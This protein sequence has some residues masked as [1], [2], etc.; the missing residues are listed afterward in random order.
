[1]RMCLYFWDDPKDTA[2]ACT[3]WWLGPAVGSQE[4]FAVCLGRRKTPDLCEVWKKGA[5]LVDV[6]VVAAP[7]RR[8]T[9]RVLSRDA[10]LAGIYECRDERGLDKVYHRATIMTMAR[11]VVASASTPALPLPPATEMRVSGTPGTPGP[12]RASALPPVAVAAGVLPPVA[13][14]VAAGALLPGSS[15]RDTLIP[16]KPGDVVVLTGDPIHSSEPMPGDRLVA[17]LFYQLKETTGTTPLI[18]SATK[19]TL[20]DMHTCTPHSPSADDGAGPAAS[21]QSWSQEK[22]AEAALRIQSQ[23]RCD[24]SREAFGAETWSGITNYST[25]RHHDKQNKTNDALHP[26]MLQ[27]EEACRPAL[28]AALAAQHKTRHDIHLVEAFVNFYNNSSARSGIGKHVDGTDLSVII[29]LTNEGLFHCYIDRVGPGVDTH[30]TIEQHPQDSDAA[31]NALQ[32]TST[33]TGRRAHSQRRCRISQ[34]KFDASVQ[35]QHL[36]V[37][38]SVRQVHARQR[39]GGAGS[40]PPL[41]IEGC[42]QALVSSPTMCMCLYFWDDPKDTAGACTG[43]WLGP[44]VGS[45]EYFA[46][47]LGRRKTPDLCEVWKKGANLVDVCVVAAPGRRSTFRVLS[48]DANL[49]GVYTKCMNKGAGLGAAVYTRGGHTVVGT[50]P[51]HRATLCAG[52]TNRAAAPTKVQRCKRVVSVRAGRMT[53]ATKDLA[54]ARPRMV[55]YFWDDPK[56]TAGAC[57]GWWLGPAVGSQEYFAVCLGR[58]K[59]PDL[60]EVWKKGANLVD[61]CVVAAPGRRSTFR[62]LSRDA[63]LAGL[64]ECSDE[65]GLDKVY[66]HATGSDPHHTDGRSRKRKRE[67]APTPTTKHQRATQKQLVFYS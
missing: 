52:T 4:Y 31:C 49:A 64:Y 38:K 55:L 18:K 21:C 34:A 41:H 60:C 32:G 46:V 61:V 30:A 24:L 20:S 58:R 44:A 1:M 65:R 39:H 51:A 37:E 26:L 45:Q 62:V 22:I 10:N 56:D 8:S 6:C 36:A 66:Y 17:L 25:A 47:C 50:T 15:K 28:G 43:W 11:A 23:W 9:F 40:A 2:S 19:G 54:R 16:L 7:G 67:A 13:V 59:T 12:N 63:N 42:P 14:A 3:G 53:H 29:Q 5:N 48:R 33:G 27:L 35:S 57:T